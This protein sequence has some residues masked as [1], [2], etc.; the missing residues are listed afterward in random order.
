MNTSDRHQERQAL[1]TSHHTSANVMI[2]FR[3][4]LTS[5]SLS[6]CK[7]LTATAVNMWSKAQNNSLLLS[8][9][10]R[11]AEHRAT[12]LQLLELRITQLFHSNC[13]IPKQH[14]SLCTECTGFQV[15]DLRVIFSNTCSKHFPCHLHS[16]IFLLNAAYA[17]IWR[18]ASPS[19][20]NSILKALRGNISPL[21]AECL[22]QHR[23]V[24]NREI[25]STIWIQTS[26]QD[27]N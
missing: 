6:A 22:M 11:K 27:N 24:T 18:L 10:V 15:R 12:H 3:S 26:A 19:H 25:Q 2:S 5:F 7:R 17:A 14:G 21:L 23:W 1:L 8:K 13:F 16:S 4:S 9:T 20:W